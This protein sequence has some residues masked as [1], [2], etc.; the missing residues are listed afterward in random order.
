M[1]CGVGGLD[2][3]DVIELYRSFFFRE[4]ELKCGVVIYGYNYEDYK[5]IQRIEV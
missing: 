4:T 5:L 2:K 1:G 3:V